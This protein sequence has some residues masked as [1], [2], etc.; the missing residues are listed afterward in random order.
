[1]QQKGLTENGWDV[2]CNISQIVIDVDNRVGHLYLP[3]MNAPD[4]RSTINCF[5]SADP[6]C[7]AIFTYV[8]GAMDTVYV[9]DKGCWSA[10]TIDPPADDNE[11][12]NY[13]TIVNDVQARY[14]TLTQFGFGGKGDIR[15]HAVER[16]VEWLL[17]HDALERRKTINHK[18]SSYYWKHVVERAC[19]EYI[20]NGEFIC[21]ALYLGY[22]M[23]A[24]GPNAFFNIK[25]VEKQ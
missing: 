13:Q 24:H 9:K 1:M 8:D 5:T 7:N 2:M 22:K 6:E 14:P 17:A 18:V 3:K 21:A 20:S 16:C 25:P 12:E 15:P 4:M 10:R 19:G 23:K 11:L